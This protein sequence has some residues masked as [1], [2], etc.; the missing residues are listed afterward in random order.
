MGRRTSELTALERVATESVV[1]RRQQ[2]EEQIEMDQLSPR[3]PGMTSN[4]HHRLSHIS[5]SDGGNLG[6]VY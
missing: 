1:L 2:T 4:G 5:G 6:G 3:P